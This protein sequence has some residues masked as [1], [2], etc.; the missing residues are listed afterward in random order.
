V[1]VET[2]IYAYLA[3]CTAMILF[4]CACIFVFRR[5]DRA[6]RRRSARLAE[7]IAGQI[8]LLRGGGPVSEEHLQSV[9]RKLRRVGN[10]MALDETLETLLAQDPDAARAYLA[11]I[12]P[13]FT[14]VAAENHYR[15]PMQLAY[16][17]YV[18]CK[19][20]ILAGR[21]IP[22]AE[23]LLMK[24][25]EEPSLYC[26]ENALQAIY[27]TGDCGFV[28]RA[29]RQVDGSGRFHHSKLLT[30]G[31]LTFSGDRQALARM[32]W[33]GFETFSIPMQTV[34]LDFIR[35]GGIPLPDELLP[36][37]AD[38][39]RDDELRFSC[40]RYFGKYPDPRA[41]PLLLSFLEHPQTHRW[42]YA[43][44]SA[45]ALVAY[46]GERTVLALKRAMSSASWYIR[47]N[48]S[49]SLEAF[50]LTYQ[51]L[52]DVMDGGDRYA[53]EILQY[54]LDVQQAQ[55]ARRSPDREY[56]EEQEAVLV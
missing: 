32:L 19:Y 36:L 1:H 12:R 31:L 21:T 18:L 16:F 30:D 52:G 23:E 17:A 3:V 51:D 46:P 25:L 39:E 45:T 10:L 11:E 7:E 26:R 5:R 34:I 28:L 2:L 29:L 48:A 24:L 9:R 41:Y 13:V 40:I 15:G 55:E 38:E 8:Q 22:L 33:A 14:W 43:A 44:I 50:H 35:F 42:E 6:L 53:R 49:R 54:R 37:L 4:N 56:T 27:S 47:F 20:R